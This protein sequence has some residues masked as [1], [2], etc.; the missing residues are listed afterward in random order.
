MKFDFAHLEAR[1]IQI[2][3]QTSTE[4]LEFTSMRTICICIGDEIYIKRENLSQKLTDLT[5]GMRSNLI[6]FMSILEMSNC[7]LFNPIIRISF[8]VVLR[9]YYNSSKLLKLFRSKY[10]TAFRSGN[11]NDQHETLPLTSIYQVTCIIHVW[12]YE[13]FCKTFLYVNMMMWI[14]HF[15]RADKYP[16][17]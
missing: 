17:S 5:K 4:T 11:Y 8:Q 15:L 10:F 3:I 16:Q 2:F 14:K 12:N 7:S 6:P 13:I 1:F 9:T